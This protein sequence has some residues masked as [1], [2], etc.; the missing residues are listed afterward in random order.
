MARGRISIGVVAPA[1]ASSPRSPRQVDGARRRALSG[2]PARDLLPSAMLPV[3]RPFRRRRRD[4]RRGLSRG[5]QRSERFDAVWFARGGYG[6]GRIAERVLPALD[7][8]GRAQDLSRLQR[9]RRPA[10]RALQ[11]GLRAGRARADA[12]R[13]PA[14]GGEAAV[15]RALA[16]LVERDADALE[17]T[18]RR[19]RPTAAFNITILSHLL[20]TPLQPD[21]PA[22]C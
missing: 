10:G 5:R 2:P 1:R 13:H 19:R 22:T 18:R 8:G 7:A 12:R 6:S 20:G 17:P 16:F 21:L 4:A 11:Q 14:R 3:V 9:R 15:T